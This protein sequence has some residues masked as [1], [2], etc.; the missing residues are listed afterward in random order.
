MVN[1]ELKNVS[2][3]R[4]IIVTETNGILLLGIY[5]VTKLIVEI[6]FNNICSL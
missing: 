1:V 2:K 3:F 4:P 5:P 6:K